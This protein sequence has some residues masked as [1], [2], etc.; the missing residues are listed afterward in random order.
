M[1]AL[2]GLVSWSSSCDSHH[3]LAS[4]FSPFSNSSDSFAALCGVIPPNTPISHTREEQFPRMTC[5]PTMHLQRHLIEMGLS[6]QRH[7]L[8]Y[9]RHIV[10]MRCCVARI[11][12]ELVICLP[13]HDDRAIDLDLFGLNSPTALN[14]LTTSGMESWYSLIWEGG[15]DEKWFGLC[16]LTC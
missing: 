1:R 5:L 2:I 10:H 7:R 13:P 8:A 12:N 16:L 14:H 9:F 11:S 15:S 4:T 3:T 6:R